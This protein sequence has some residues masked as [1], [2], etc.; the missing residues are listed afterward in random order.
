MMEMSEL[1]PKIN[2]LATLIILVVSVA[3]FIG[4][5]MMAKAE[6]RRRQEMSMAARVG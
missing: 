1:I 4:W 3:T 6:K 2:A 5:W